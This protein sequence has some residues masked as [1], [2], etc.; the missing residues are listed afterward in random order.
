MGL[1][2]QTLSHRL[3][4][5]MLCKFDEAMSDMYDEL[6][7]TWP[8]PLPAPQAPTY[9]RGVDVNRISFVGAFELQQAYTYLADHHRKALFLVCHYVDV[10]IQV[11]SGRML[12]AHGLNYNRTCILRH[13]FVRRHP[14]SF[15]D[16]RRVHIDSKV[17]TIRRPASETTSWHRLYEDTYGT[18]WLDIRI[19]TANQAKS[20]FMLRRDS[21]RE[22]V[23]WLGY[24]FPSTVHLLARHLHL[25]DTHAHEHADLVLHQEL[26]HHHVMTADAWPSNDTKRPSPPVDDSVVNTSMAWLCDDDPNP[27]IDEGVVETLRTWPQRRLYEKRYDDNCLQTLDNIVSLKRKR[28]I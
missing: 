25:T 26:F 18:S 17:N 23:L 15:R 21:K 3:L 19:D 27:W 22:R 9:Q 4:C 12:V 13:E 6:F 11:Q 5:N 7:G 28:L 8:T 24:T 20:M 14:T 16:Y 2:K 1:G 10:L